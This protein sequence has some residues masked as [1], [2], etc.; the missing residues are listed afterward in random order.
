MADSGAGVPARSEVLRHRE[1]PADLSKWTEFDA[2]LHEHVASGKWGEEI[3][4]AIRANES[5]NALCRSSPCTR[6][7]RV[8]VLG[9]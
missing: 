3:R 4:A 6:D 7:Q 5:Q 2:S 8:C 9:I 1:S